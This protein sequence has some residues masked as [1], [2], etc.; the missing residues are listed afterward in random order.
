[1]VAI[2]DTNRSIIKA[3]LEVFIE[4][5]VERYRNRIISE[6]NSPGEYLNLTSN[7]GDLKPFHAAIIP[8]EILR[9]S[10]F[11][12]GFVTSL[13]TTFEECAKIIA[14]QHH[15]NARRSYDV[16]GDVDIDSINEIERQV[17]NFEHKVEKNE[18]RPTFQ[19]MVSSVLKSSNGKS[20]VS[21]TARA[22]L[23]V[24][25][26]DGTEYYFEIKSPKPNKGQCLEV[27]Q[28]LLRF[29]AI[30][31]Q[32]YPNLKTYYAMAYN[33]YGNSRET[34][35]WSMAMNYMPYTEA[36]L[37]G[38]EFWDIIGGNTTYTELLSIYQEVGQEKAKYI[39]DALAFGF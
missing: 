3:Y 19:N 36:L 5:L 4:N 2:S 23:Y 33:P 27:T 10:A 29:H 22:D 30:R 8:T 12:R 39:I 6:M 32:D 16:I 18:T 25:S 31:A 21:R 17:S 15:K 1:M 28:R 38:H 11:Q 34:Y 35:T 7:S 26:H 37:I 9:I 24:L 20:A 14:L 13:G